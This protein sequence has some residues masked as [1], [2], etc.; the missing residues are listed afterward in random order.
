MD[1][2]RCVQ[3]IPDSHKSGFSFTKKHCLTATFFFCAWVCFLSRLAPLKKNVTKLWYDT[4]YKTFTS[5]KTVTR[6]VQ[7]TDLSVLHFYFNKTFYPVRHSVQ[8]VHLIHLQLLPSL[9]S[10]VL[11]SLQPLIHLIKIGG[12]TP[13]S[14]NHLSS[15][16]SGPPMCASNLSLVS[17]KCQCGGASMFLLAM[18]FPWNAPFSVHPAYVACFNRRWLWSIYFPTGCGNSTCWYTTI[19]RPAAVLLKL[20]LTHVDAHKHQHTLSIRLDKIRSDL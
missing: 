7:F 17:L 11:V 12:L 1:G 8:S 10:S 3:N 18:D 19:V 2:F 20:W 15:W 14:L 9:T 5:Y 16:F 6:L 4:C 13:I